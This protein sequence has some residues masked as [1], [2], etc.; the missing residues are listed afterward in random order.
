[1]RSVFPGVA[2]PSP[3]T[4]LLAMSPEEKGWPCTG[5]IVPACRRML[6]R[7]IKVEWDA[8]E[9]GVYPLTLK[10]EA[11]DRQNLLVD[12]MNQMSLLKLNVTAANIHMDKGMAYLDF[13]I[14]V[15]HINQAKELV[16][17]LKMING[18]QSIF[19]ISKSRKRKR[20]SQ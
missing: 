18:V 14:E 11:V 17:K 8:E 12:I 3:A 5:L 13:T 7:F 20:I 19:R 6:E 2:T 9:R 1:M 10:I 4:K 15:S 16:G